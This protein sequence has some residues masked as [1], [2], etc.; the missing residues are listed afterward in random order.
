VVTGR[1]SQITACSQALLDQ[2]IALNPQI[3]ARSRVVHNGVDLS[4]FSRAVPFKHTRPYI[5]SVGQLEVHKGFDILVSA[6]ST[7]TTS[8]TDIDVL[9]AGDGS[10]RELLQHQ[11]SNG[12]LDGRVFFLGSCN[13]DEVVSLMLGCLYVVIPS[14]RE[15]FGIVALEA[16]AAR[17]PIIASKVGGL[18]EALEGAN[19]V[20]VEP[21]NVEALS[22]AMQQL[23]RDMRDS[24]PNQTGMVEDLGR[25]FSWTNVASRYLAVYGLN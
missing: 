19:P 20:W 5:L 24:E 16:R 17:K 14:R 9:I 8:I 21:G 1:A 25:E 10:Q 7:L 15:P 11:V 12:G 4:I 6:F 23:A 18:P 2:A 3:R 22:F 13:P